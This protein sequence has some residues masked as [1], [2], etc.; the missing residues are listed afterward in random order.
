MLRLRRLRKTTCILLPL[1]GLLA[2]P[3][4]GRAA[5]ITAKGSDSMVILAQKWAEVYMTRRP[6]VQIQVTGGGSGTGFAAL[7]NRTTDL[8]NASRP[9]KAREI[10]ACIRSFGARPREYR[11]CLDGVSVYVNRRNPINELSLAQI[12]AIFR[13]QI[14][15]WRAVGGPDLPIV[16]YGR[17]NSSGTYEFFKRHV[18]EGHDYA[19]T[20]QSMPGTAAVLQAIARDQSGIGYGGA[21]Y[22]RDGKTLKIRLPGQAVAIAPT[23]ENVTDGRYPISRHLYVYLDPALDRGPIAD[24]MQWILGTEGQAIVGEVGYY[25]LPDTEMR[26]LP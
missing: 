5:A 19:T 7:Q 2:L 20:A 6:G 4:S 14:D 3:F 25:P 8:C 11:V 21:A 1:C 10:L 24:F 18:L 9:I 12:G 22:G 15:N 26:L 23:R 17:E 16:I 13:G